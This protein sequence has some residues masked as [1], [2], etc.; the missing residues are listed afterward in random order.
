MKQMIPRNWDFMRI[1]RLAIGIAIVTQSVVSKDW[2]FGAAGLM[3]T[4]MAILNVGC[5]G[6]GACYTNPKINSS[7]VKDTTYEEVV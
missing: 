6:A 4:G 2:L 3:F 7:A 5:C 1:F